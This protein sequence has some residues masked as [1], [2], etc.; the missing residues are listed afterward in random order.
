MV[1]LGFCRDL[2]HVDGGVEDNGTQRE[3]V[4]VT[5]LVEQPHLERERLQASAQ[6]RDPRCGSAAY[7]GVPLTGAFQSSFPD[8]RQMCHFG[9]L[10][11][12]SLPAA[13]EARPRH[14]RPRGL[15]EVTMPRSRL[16]PA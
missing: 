15:Q 14:R 10:S 9:K 16:A 8:Y 2:S 12:A 7:R 13:S 4:Q 1:A 6:S 11:D 3:Y 5:E